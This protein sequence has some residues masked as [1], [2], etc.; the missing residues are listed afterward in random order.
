MNHTV[1]IPVR[2]QPAA[3]RRP[4]SRRPESPRPVSPRP[5][6]PR[7]TS[8]QM[9]PVSDA[10]PPVE[11]QDQQMVR[12]P[13]ATVPKPVQ[14]DESGRQA[15]QMKPP[16][17]DQRQDT[18]SIDSQEVWRDRALRLQAEMDN[19]RKR[20]QRLAEDS[21]VADRERLLGA[22]LSISD[23]LDRA[24]NADGGDAEVLRQGVDLT[25]QKLMGLLRMEGAERIEALGQPFD[26]TFHE[27]VGT[28]PYQHAGVAPL[29]VVDVVE[30]GYRLDTR[31]LRPARVIVAT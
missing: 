28:V 15:A 30:A 17:G 7:P 6:S 12:E 13:V 24:L 26:P 20:Q 5:T 25:R 8:R 2:V 14:D 22:F 19:F 1:R 11:D 27:A 18:K 23:D 3:D 31:L 29:T 4:S 10:V 21:V 16:V 9:P